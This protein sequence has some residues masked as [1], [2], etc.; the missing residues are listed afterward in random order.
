MTETTPVVRQKI[1]D[2]ASSAFAEKGF[3]GARVDEIAN[4]AGVNKAMLYYHVGDKEAL[5]GEI[6]KQNFGRIEEALD[7]GLPNEGS[8]SD[9]LRA[10]IAIVESAIATNPDHP[11][12]VLREF[13]SG[14]SFLPDE[15]LKRMLGLLTV[16]R[17]I[18]EE[19]TASGEFRRTDPVMTHLSLIGAILMLS[20]ASPLRERVIDLGSD[21]AFPTTDADVGRFLGDLLLEGIATPKSGEPP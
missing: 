2:A 8:A 9:R 16:V 10:A 13:A 20:V 11:R 1:L 12:I 3:A 6:L 18:L 19:G 7:E 17:D 21:V 14:A 5:Y 4:R 15:I